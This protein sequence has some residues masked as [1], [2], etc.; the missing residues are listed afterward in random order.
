M[1]GT[2]ILAYHRAKHEYF[3]CFRN[4][5]YCFRSTKYDI[6]APVFICAFAI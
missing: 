4:K 2:H 3:Y 1:S 5:S 6:E